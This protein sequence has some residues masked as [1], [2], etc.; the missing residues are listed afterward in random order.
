MTQQ[1]KKL[2]KR[3]K[4]RKKR[5]L[6]KAGLINPSI[7]VVGPGPEAQGYIGGDM[8]ALLYT[9]AFAGGVGL[10]HVEWK[11]PGCQAA[12]GMPAGGSRCLGGAICA[13]GG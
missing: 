2:K 4:G 12:S 7:E 8:S 10:S 5:R 9:D 11:P 6:L 13:A 3:E 1:E